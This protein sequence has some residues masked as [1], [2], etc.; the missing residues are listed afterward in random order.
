M[1][2][3]TQIRAF[4][5]LAGVGFCACAQAQT[6]HAAH[7]GQQNAP[8]FIAFERYCVQSSAEPKAIEESVRQSGGRLIFSGENKKTVE[9]TATKSWE[10]RIGGSAI[11]VSAVT[12]MRAHWPQHFACIVSSQATDRASIEAARAW[13]G[14]APWHDTGHMWSYT[15]DE[16]GADRKRVAVST[17]SPNLPPPSADRRRWMLEVQNSYGTEF[18]LWRFP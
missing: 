8:L 17:T 11:R 16:V 3:A 13:V 10:V 9:Q 1:M 15:Y 4:L 2:H 14:F 18:E 12:I 7:P 6:S 5:I